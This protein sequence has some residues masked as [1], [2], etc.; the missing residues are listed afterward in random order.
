[1]ADW[2]VCL[3]ACCLA[4]AVSTRLLFFRSNNRR[5]LGVWFIITRGLSVLSA[6]GRFTERGRV[7]VLHTNGLYNIPGQT[8]FLSFFFFFYLSPQPSKRKENKQK[9]RCQTSSGRECVEIKPGPLFPRSTFRSH[10]TLFII[11][12]TREIV[13]LFFLSLSLYFY[14]C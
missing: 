6:Q 13:E 10:T 1:M 2:P 11:P 8:Q 5:V 4:S 12:G 9:K 3:L 14:S 7:I